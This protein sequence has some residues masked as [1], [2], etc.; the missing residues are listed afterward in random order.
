[1]LP[2]FALA[3][4]IARGIADDLRLL[5]AFLEPPC[6]RPFI[7]MTPTSSSNTRDGDLILSSDFAALTAARGG[8]AHSGDDAAAPGVDARRQAAHSIEPGGAKQARGHG[9][10]HSAAEPRGE[11]KG[12]ADETVLSHAFAD[13]GGYVAAGRLHARG[14]RLD[15]QRTVERSFEVGGDSLGVCGPARLSHALRNTLLDMRADAVGIEA[16]EHL[17]DGLQVGNVL[18]AD[19]PALLDGGDQ[20]A[21]VGGQLRDASPRQS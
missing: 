19:L 2:A 21:Y 11:Q 13:T 17:R 7:A 12:F 20:F 14:R 1:M 15:A 3:R 16:V 10:G 6:P 18:L 5:L 8:G 4:Q 9:G